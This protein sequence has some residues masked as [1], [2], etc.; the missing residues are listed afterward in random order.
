M[1]KT[2]MK[3]ELSTLVCKD[4]GEINTQI[5]SDESNSS[6][7]PILFIGKNC[8]HFSLFW[9]DAFYDEQLN[10]KYL[11]KSIICPTCHKSKLTEIGLIRPVEME[12]KCNRCNSTNLFVLSIQSN[13][14]EGIVEK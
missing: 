1:K 14:L 10:K 4:C 12:L 3:I 7:L 2:T 11:S 9:Q 13:Y 6:T 5:K 8:S